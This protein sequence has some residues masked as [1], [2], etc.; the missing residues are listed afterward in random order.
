MIHSR[1][2]ARETDSMSKRNSASHLSGQFKKIHMKSAR[3]FGAAGAVLTALLALALLPSGQAAPQSGSLRI[4]ASNAVRTTVE[5]LRAQCERSVGRTLSIE[6]NPSTAIS[7]E[8]EAGGA[9]DVVIGASDLIDR[10][11]AEG[12]LPASSRA[13]VARSAVGIGVRVKASQSR[14]L[15]RP[16]EAMKRLL[17][18][19]KAISYTKDG[20]SQPLILKMA[21]SLGIA[22][23][24]NAK[25]MAEV[26]TTA[27]GADVVGGKAD[28]LL[29]MTSEILPIQGLELV[30]PI[31][32]AFDRYLTFSAGASAKSGDR[33]ASAAVIKFLTAPSVATVLKSKGMEPVG[34]K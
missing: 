20:A 6:Y 27:A 4:L 15:G 8:I 9:F 11:I 24:V 2:S 16:R 10:L 23:Q 19:A 13:D 30:G 17:L 32:A 22:D 7:K 33:K 12:K 26:T 18:G 21:Q 25:T 14:T 28:V 31:P 1:S 5:E 29:T 3:R 34:H